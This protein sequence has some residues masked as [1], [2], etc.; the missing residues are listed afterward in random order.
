[1][2]LPGMTTLV[3]G[4][5]GVF[6]TA[7]ARRFAAEGARVVMTDI[8]AG[9]LKT[10]AEHVREDRADATAPATGEPGADVPEPDVLEIAADLVDPGDVARL[11]AELDARDLALDVLVN[12][13]GCVVRSPLKFHTDADW[14]RVLRVN[15]DSVFH[16]SREAVRRML[17]RRYGRIVN[18][19]SVLG[20]TGGAEEI[21]YSTAKAGVIG[22]TK[23]LAQEV[24]RRDIRV[25]ALCPTL[26]DSGVS[27]DWFAGLGVDPNTVAAFLARRTG[28]SRAI[29]PDDVADAA[30][31]LG[32]RECGYV[33]G[34]A[35]VLGGVTG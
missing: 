5:A 16:C 29:G 15:L 12:N 11:F 34:Q 13:A 17:P 19:S 20:L 32:S 27:R 14:H 22:F 7:I 21:A 26:V 9:G 6:G 2:R 30:V 23:S 4:A 24:G 28:M 33:N 1:M 8:D 35:L 3:T 18:V 31:F 25:N 10:A